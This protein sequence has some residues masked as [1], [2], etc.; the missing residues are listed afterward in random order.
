MSNRPGRKG[1][2]DAQNKRKE[3]RVTGTA[4][5][6]RSGIFSAV[7][8]GPQQAWDKAAPVRRGER[9]AQPT[10]SLALLRAAPVPGH[11]VGP[12]VWVKHG[13]RLF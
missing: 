9:R 13:D 10:D 7:A 4:L 12:R 8:Q 3:L 6:S 2:R 5:F 11:R 1:Q